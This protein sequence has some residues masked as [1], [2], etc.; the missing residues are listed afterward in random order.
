MT[1]LFDRPPVQQQPPSRASRSGSR[2]RR[3]AKKR[4][5]RRRR[6]ALIIVLALALV[7]GA[8]FYLVTNA[9]N[10]LG[11]ENPFSASDYEG[12]GTDPVEVTIDQGSTGTDMGQVLLDAGVVKSVNAFV[13]AYKATPEASSIQPGNYTLLTEM[14][15][16]A[17]VS[18]LLSKEAKNEL[19]LTIP[20]GF[21][22]AQVID[23]AV[24]VTGKPKEEFDAAMA[25][26]AALG[27]PAEAGGNFEGWLAPSTYILEPSDTAETILANMVVTTISNLDSLGVAPADRQ[28]VIIKGSLVERE[29]ISLEQFGKV[30]RVIENRL[31]V[32]EPLSLDAIDSYGRG[33]KS[34]E[35]TTQE[36]QDKSFPYASRVN[37]GLP[38]TPI[39]SPGIAALTAVVSPTEGDWLWYVTVNLDTGETK[40]TNNY[41]EFVRFK[42]EFKA[43]EAE[44]DG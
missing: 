8:G 7:G 15:A 25:D 35:I 40:F 9:S 2:D 5:Q 17:A 10:L 11:F 28:T 3:A 33:K 4:A 32:G 18:L 13:E 30:A 19:K 31:A 21:T 26:P 1:D 37:K 34:S 23:R 38:P 27:L 39:G 14:K 42:R 44:Q 29:G 43:W 6:R 22:K 24:S 36:F 16:S 20:E 41:N 12:Q